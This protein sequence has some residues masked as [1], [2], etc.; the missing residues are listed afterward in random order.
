M[1]AVE[2]ERTVSTG[3][4]PQTYALDRATTGTGELS[5]FDINILKP[6]GFFTY[7]QVEHTKILHGARFALSILYGSQN[8]DF[9][10]TCH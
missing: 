1:P 5:M 8:S 7:H 2:F 3:E 9:C 10:F 4:R 6:S